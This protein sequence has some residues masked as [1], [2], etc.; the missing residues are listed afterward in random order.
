MNEPSSELVKRKAKGL[1]VFRQNA[2]RQVP[3]AQKLPPRDPS[4]Y[5]NTHQIELEVQPIVFANP[6]NASVQKSIIEGM[7]TKCFVKGSKPPPGMFDEEWEKKCFRWYFEIEADKGASSRNWFFDTRII[8]RMP[9]LHLKINLLEI[10]GQLEA[11]GDNP[12]GSLS[13]LEA[14]GYQTPKAQQMILDVSNTHKTE[15][16]MT[17][18]LTYSLLFSVIFSSLLTFLYMFFVLLYRK[19]SYVH[20]CLRM[21]NIWSKKLATITV[22]ICTKWVLKSVF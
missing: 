20:L 6:A 5:A 22:L 14:Y 21:R 4:E 12:E 10:C 17:T 9:I 2:P 19:N 16:M 7:L 1:T 3:D 18:I 8:M 15:V 13:V 11:L